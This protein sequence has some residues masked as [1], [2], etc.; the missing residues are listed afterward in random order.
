VPWG[1]PI[2]DSR[3]K[4]ALNFQ[5]NILVYMLISIPLICIF[6]MGIVT[7]IAAGMYPLVMSILAG[8]KA[9]EGQMDTYPATVRVIQ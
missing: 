3:G 6:G 4:E 7:R 9:N 2:L 5:L 1:K 8:L